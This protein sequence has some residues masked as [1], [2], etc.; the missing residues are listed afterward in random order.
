MQN[1]YHGNKG[2][3]ENIFKE[4]LVEEILR[5]VET[6]QQEKNRSP[7]MERKQ[8]DQSLSKPR[9]VCAQMCKNMCVLDA[10]TEVNLEN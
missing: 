2:E 8:N 7:A 6:V 3:G 10:E 5:I 4:W 9:Y 1:N